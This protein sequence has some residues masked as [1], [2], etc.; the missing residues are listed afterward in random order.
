MRRFFLILIAV[1]AVAEIS[2]EYARAETS[3]WDD[4]VA[5]A[6]GQTVYWHAWGGDE[7]VNRYIAWA[8]EQVRDKYGIT[9]RHVRVGNI[10]ESVTLLVAEKTG[11]RTK[12]GRIDLLWLNGENFAAL[13]NADLLY[14]PFTQQLPN[15]AYVDTLNKPT[16]LVDFTLPTDG[17]EA[18]WGM[19]QIVFFAD[20]AHVKSP[21]RSLAELKVWATEN[22][23]RFT[24]PAPPDFTGTTFLKQGLM[25]LVGDRAPLYEPV[26]EAGFASL[27][28]PLWRFLDALHPTLWRSGKVFPASYPALRQL[29]NDGAIDIAFSFNPAEVSS[30]VSRQLLP[31][32][33]KPFVFKQGTIGN[34][35]FVGI[36]KTASAKEGAM[37]VANFLLSP[38]AQA[39]KA[40]PLVWG[41][42]TVLDIEK[43]DATSSA[44]FRDISHDDL[45]L[46]PR[47]LSRV[48]SE[49]H[50][51]WT[52]RLEE[53]WQRRYQR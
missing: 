50:P 3:D 16:T 17:L 12:D 31:A 27:S 13:K 39:H 4:V 32:T 45:M 6:D 20:T 33:V 35:H 40:D 24:Y 26:T 48:L 14:G 11:G 25:D 9:L 36:P 29:M 42:P 22:P 28:A 15:F 44:L 1:F 8:A 46:G 21:P 34:S 38:V 23:G 18:P 43:L 19:A 5:A 2:V 7:N 51:S 10:S 41:D 47:D 30:A 37:V 53:E 49:P 52:E